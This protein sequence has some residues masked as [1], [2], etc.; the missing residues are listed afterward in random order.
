MR[1][2]WSLCP[3]E[4]ALCLCLLLSNNIFMTSLPSSDYILASLTHFSL[5]NCTIQ[6][7]LKKRLKRCIPWCK[8]IN[9]AFL[10]VTFTH[11][12]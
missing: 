8:I 11:K 4:A 9:S 5:K 12:T 2:N 3:H 10:V 6:H 1:G 7:L